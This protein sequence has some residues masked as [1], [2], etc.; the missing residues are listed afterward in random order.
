L[1]SVAYSNGARQNA[2]VAF[3]VSNIVSRNFANTFSNCY[4]MI[5]NFFD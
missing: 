5:D 2:M 3:N 1:N 4:T